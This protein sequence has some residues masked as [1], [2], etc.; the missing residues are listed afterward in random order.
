MAYTASTAAV[1]AAMGHQ[2]SSTFKTNM[3]AAVDTFLSDLETEA[4]AGRITEAEANEIDAVMI[5]T[6]CSLLGNN[7]TATV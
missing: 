7:R 2:P 3:N 4:T 1:D 5:D 6:V